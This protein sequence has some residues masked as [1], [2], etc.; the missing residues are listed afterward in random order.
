MRH[1]IKYYVSLLK[2][3]NK[4]VRT[5]SD[6]REVAKAFTNYVSSENDARSLGKIMRV[7]DASIKKERKLALVEV[8]V[9]DK[10]EITIELQKSLKEKLAPWYN[11]ILIHAKIKKELI[12]GMRLMIDKS[13]SI[14][15]SCRDLVESL[16]KKD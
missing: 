6:A 10:D 4:E 9:C 15:A 8:S 14:N 11:D 3:L 16:F 2:E 1:P 7:F 13:F 12:S 5:D